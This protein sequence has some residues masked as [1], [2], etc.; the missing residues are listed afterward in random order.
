[1]QVTNRETRV[2]TNF[3]CGIR[4]PLPMARLRNGFIPSRDRRER[5]QNRFKMEGVELINVGEVQPREEYYLQLERGNILFFPRTPFELS[6]N[7]RNVLRATGL[8]TSS[9]HKNIAYRAASDKVTG[10]DKAMVQNPDELRGMMSAYSQRVRGLLR[11][12]L[13]LYMENCR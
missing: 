1:M 3:N 9:H 7:E 6:E 11:T 8:S 2:V 4:K 10:F 5:C 12:L 13:H